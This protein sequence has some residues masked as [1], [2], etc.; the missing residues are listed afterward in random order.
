MAS[1]DSWNRAIIQHFT[2]G[3]P[4]GNA[5]Y[6]SVDEDVI[7]QIASTQNALLVAP[8]DA[9]LDFRRAVRDRVVLEGR[10]VA[11]TTIERRTRVD[12]PG[13]VAFLALMVLAASDMAEEEREDSGRIDEKDYFRR[14]RQRLGL[15]AIPGRPDGLKTG[16][17]EPLWVDWNRWLE[18]SGFVSTARPG[19]TSN[20]KYINYPISQT[21]LRK[22]DKDRLRRR[23]FS[24][25]TSRWQADLDGETLLIQLR[26]DAHVTSKYLVGLL[27]TPGVRYQAL[28]DSLY[29]LHESWRAG[30]GAVTGFGRAANRTLRCGLFRTCDPIMGTIEYRLYPR[31]PA[32]RRTESGVLTQGGEAIALAVERSGWFAPLDPVIPAELAAGARYSVAGIDGVTEA[33]LPK[34]AFWVLVTD[35]QEPEN[36]FHASWRHPTL[37]EPAI[38]LIADDTLSLIRQLRDEGLVEWEREP[39]PVP[40]LPGWSEV[41]NCLVVSEALGGVFGE[42]Q[43]IFEE[44]RP[45][46]KLGISTKGGLRS[47]DRQGW[48]AGLGP[49]ITVSGF[50]SEVELCVTRVTG[51]GEDGRHVERTVPCFDPQ[52]FPFETPGTYRID[53]TAGGHDAAPRLVRLIAWDQLAAEPTPDYS[54][55]PIGDWQIIGAT[56]RPTPMEVR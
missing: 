44:L 45:A 2:A 6:L 20:R 46:T 55:V 7:A 5:V 25:S 19:D 29:D 51:D 39:I 11:L 30:P 48:V 13:G 34:R 35:P 38:V 14:L 23:V 32:G 56:V 10:R 54:A 47:P 21:L 36:G 52:P 16:A 12:E 18:A 31:T 42:A 50:D 3:I 49:D 27:A 24:R 9:L 15:E 41:Q 26:N 53:A 40:S 37:G 43:A 28:T 8:A 17:E 1:Y 33:V 22:A 4:L